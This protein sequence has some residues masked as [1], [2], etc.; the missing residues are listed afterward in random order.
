M[1]PQ[2]LVS[3]FWS[4]LL[5]PLATSDLFS[6]PLILYFPECH[7]NLFIQL[8]YSFLY[9]FYIYYILQIVQPFEFGFFHFTYCNLGLCMLLQGSRVIK[10]FL[11]GSIALYVCTYHSLLTHQTGEEHLAFGDYEKKLLKIFL[12]GFLHENTYSFYLFIVHV[13]YIYIN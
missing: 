8:L 13:K 12:F 1:K 4:A 5:Q 6:V 2:I 10:S 7:V 9:S 11:L 3:S